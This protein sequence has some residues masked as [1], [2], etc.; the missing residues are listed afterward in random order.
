MLDQSTTVCASYLL[1]SVEEVQ[2]P[3]LLLMSV[4]QVINHSMGKENVDVFA[5]SQLLR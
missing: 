1:M 4:R 2:Q 3:L 5:N